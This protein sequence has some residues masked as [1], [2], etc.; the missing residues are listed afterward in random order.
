M[1]LEATP[2]SLDFYRLGGWEQGGDTSMWHEVLQAQGNRVR[3]SVP[4]VTA[5]GYT[6]SFRPGCG[7][8]KGKPRDNQAGDSRVP[9]LHGTLHRVR[10]QEVGIQ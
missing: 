4:H 1:A 6:P 9:A 8:R 5:E 2:A 7:C 3:P 10:N